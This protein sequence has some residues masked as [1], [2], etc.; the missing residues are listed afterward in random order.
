[1]TP[2]SC[3]NKTNAGKLIFEG[4]NK[5]TFYATLSEMWD[6]DGPD[7]SNFEYSLVIMTQ[8]TN[9]LNGFPVNRA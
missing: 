2:G 3:Q 8:K 5:I 6:L 4:V 9:N 7:W 1:M